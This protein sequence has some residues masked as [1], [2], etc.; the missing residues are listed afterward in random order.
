LLQPLEL[1]KHAHQETLLK[2]PLLLAV[3]LSLVS[4]LA[5]PPLQQ[6]LPKRPMM[7]PFTS[8]V[9]AQ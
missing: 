2:L 1:A 3:W 6:I 8:I 9:D 5:T 4:A 7:R